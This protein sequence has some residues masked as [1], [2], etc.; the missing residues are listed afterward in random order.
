MLSLL[1][2]ACITTEIYRLLLKFHLNF[3]MIVAMLIKFGQQLK[4]RMRIIYAEFAGD[5]MCQNGDRSI[6]SGR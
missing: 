4:N 3:Y 2:I 6:V 5:I 1:V